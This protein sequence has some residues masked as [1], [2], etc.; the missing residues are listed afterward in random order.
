MEPVVTPDSQDVLT[1]VV[2]E[3]ENGRIE[4]DVDVSPADADDCT[5]AVGPRHVLV[6]CERLDE[7]YE[8]VVTPPSRRHVFDGERRA[9]YNNGVLTVSV[10][11]TR[12]TPGSFRHSP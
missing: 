4:I 8:R 10:E 7:Q 12:R 6:A 5:V 1:R 3:R 11:T 9:I 2:H